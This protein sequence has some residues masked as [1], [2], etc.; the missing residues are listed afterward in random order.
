MKDIKSGGSRKI[1]GNKNKCAKYRLDQRRI[2]NKIRRL[3]KQFKKFGE[4]DIANRIRKLE[5]II[6]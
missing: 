1:G 5:D 6:I 3:K 2:K 4:P